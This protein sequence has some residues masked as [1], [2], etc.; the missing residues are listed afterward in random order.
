[1][2]KNHSVSGLYYSQNGLRYNVVVSDQDLCIINFWALFSREPQFFSFN[3]NNCKKNHYIKSYKS[4]LR[5]HQVTLKVV[6]CW[7]VSDSAMLFAV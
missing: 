2:V 6:F 1:M 4:I 5:N 3:I 7:V